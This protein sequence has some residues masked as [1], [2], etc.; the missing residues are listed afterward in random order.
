MNKKTIIQ[1]KIRSQ[2]CFFHKLKL[3]QPSLLAFAKSKIF[4]NSDAED[5][6]SKTTSIIVEKK[7]TYK[8]DGNFY[9]WCFRILHFQIKAFFTK[10]KRN[11]EHLMPEDFSPD[12]F[13]YSLFQVSNHLPFEPLLKKELEQEQRKTLDT[14]RVTALTDRE[15]EFFDYHMSGKSK[16]FIVKAMNLS[17][18]GQYYTWKTRVTN[19]LK[20]HIAHK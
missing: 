20:S 7:L 6:V 2:K 10:T 12:S 14:L 18:E 8:E 13:A 4:N 19:R 1:E 5:V 15:R 17:K 9:A 3:I 16:A 11:R